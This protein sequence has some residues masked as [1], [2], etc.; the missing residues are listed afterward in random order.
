MAQD[1]VGGLF[2]IQQQPDYY[3]QDQRAAIDIANL[4]NPQAMGRYFGAMVGAPLGRAVAQGIGGLMGYE[5]PRLKQA[6]VIKAAQQQGFDV[7]TPE[8]LQQLASFFVQNGEPGL[9]S[10]VA[11]QMQAAQKAT[12]EYTKSAEDYQREKA[13]REAVAALPQE[14]RTEDNIMQLAAQYGTT[15]TVMSA[16]A[17][18]TGKREAILAR[19]EAA[20]AKSDEKKAA[21]EEKATKAKENALAAIGPILDTLDKTIPMVGATTAGI[22]GW[23]LG[24]V[25]GTTA[26]DLRSNI[27]TIKANL[28]FQQLQAMRDASPTGGALGQV[29]VQE[30]KALQDTV[31]ALDPEQSPA[32]LKENLLKVQKHYE[33]WKRT[34]EGDLGVAP[35][36]STSAQQTPD[37][38]PLGIRR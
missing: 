34:L 5:D 33:N 32:Q 13:F 2:G 21:A 38:D 4:N 15:S 14:Q 23:A 24:I 35:R 19:Q 22:G 1:I 18:L 27:G 29:A 11:Q 37:N 25:P 17:N 36:Q 3:A 8:G 12:L 7:T 31:S 30:L 28:G 20:Q 10:Q 9:A 26:R 16:L 6:G